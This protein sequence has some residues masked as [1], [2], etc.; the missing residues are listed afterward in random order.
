M[1]ELQKTQRREITIK[2]SFLSFGLGVSCLYVH[3]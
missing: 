3:L 2:R 1:E